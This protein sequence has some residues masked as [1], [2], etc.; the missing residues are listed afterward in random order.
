MTKTEPRWRKRGWHTAS[1]AKRFFNDVAQYLS[2][3]GFQPGMRVP[4]KYRDVLAWLL[5]GQLEEKRISHFT[6]CKSARR[7]KH[8]GRLLD[9]AFVDEHFVE[10]RISV[11][12]ALRGKYRPEALADVF[13]D[14]HT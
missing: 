10:H 12:R 1:A 6:V 4:E 7:S 8:F 2:D 13:S 14:L 5:E 9:F 3:N 11:S